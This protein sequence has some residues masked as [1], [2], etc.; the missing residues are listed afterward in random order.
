M[1]RVLSRDRSGEGNVLFLH[2]WSSVLFLE[3][4]LGEM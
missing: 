3:G 4:D 1:G 2:F